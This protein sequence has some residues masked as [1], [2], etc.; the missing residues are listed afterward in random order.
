MNLDGTPDEE[1]IAFYDL[2]GPWDPLDVT[3]AAELMTG[4]VEP[5]WVVGGHA[6]EAFCGVTRRHEDCDVVFFGKDLA[7]FR[8][9]IGDRFHLWA[10]GSG[11]LR[12]IN[13]RFPELPDW[14]GQVWLRENALRPWRLD[15]PVNPDVGG[16][17][18]SKRDADH[19][20][21]LDEVTWVD[22]AGIRFLVPEIVLLHKARLDRPK[23]LVDL[24]AAWP[25]MSPSQRDWLR[26]TMARMYPDHAWNDRLTAD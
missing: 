3:G 15:C 16:R 1:D 11:A 23:D 9:H 6:I 21:D 17:W 7:R 12:P 2:Y 24:E 22:E 14:A 4:F 18:Q 25:L 26:Q 20:A 8:E 13:D 5:W 19:V 10:V